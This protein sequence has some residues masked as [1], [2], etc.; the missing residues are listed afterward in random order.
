MQD[1]LPVCLRVIH[2]CKT[3]HSVDPS[4]ING[5]NVFHFTGHLID[6]LIRYPTITCEVVHR[7]I[8]EVVDMAIDGFGIDFGWN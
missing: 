1:V 7:C 2:D 4:E 6:L 8:E 3:S 5:V